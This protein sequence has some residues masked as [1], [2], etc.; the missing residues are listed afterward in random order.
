MAFQAKSE[1]AAGLSRISDHHKRP[2]RI[3]K[4]GPTLSFFSGKT[5]VSPIISVKSVFFLDG[6]GAD[7]V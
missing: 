5:A 7:L 6:D 3:I 2:D 4:Q 1:E